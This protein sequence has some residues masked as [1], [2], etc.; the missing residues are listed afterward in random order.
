MG[1]Q[2]PKCIEPVDIADESARTV[3]PANI[4]S[5]AVGL[6]KATYSQHGDENMQRQ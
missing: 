1:P 4:E 3:H 6:S 2:F 5:I